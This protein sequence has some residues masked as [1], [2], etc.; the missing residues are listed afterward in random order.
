MKPREMLERLLE[1]LDGHQPST[2]VE[3]GLFF[4]GSTALLAL[5]YDL[6]R[7][8]AIEKA[9]NRL[10]AL[11]VLLA[12]RGLTER[13]SVH[14]G[15]DQ[16]D[17]SRL[18]QLVDEDFGAD[19]RL[20]CVLD[21]ASHELELTRSSFEVLFPRLREGGIYVIEDWG[22]GHFRFAREREGPS[23]ARLVVEL[24]LSLPY[25]EELVDHIEVNRW[26]AVI[27]RGPAPATDP[28]TLTEH[29]SPRGHRLLAGEDH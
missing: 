15:V 12:E 8:C 18:V 11:A 14:E 29:L 6:D 17:R 10:E 19:A 20:D 5:R 27:H 23:M 21:D 2:M 28:L 7:L 25:D 22:W 3:V 26:F 1:V 9:E 13:V 16:G 24:L 4:G